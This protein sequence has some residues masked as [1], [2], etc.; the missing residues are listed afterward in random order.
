MNIPEKI[1]AA[2]AGLSYHGI[3]VPVRHLKHIRDAPAFVVFALLS[4]RGDFYSDDE[5]EATESVYTVDLFVNGEFAALL[6]EVKHRLK[7][8]GFTIMGT[9]PEIWE[10]GA[11]ESTGERGFF[12]IP[13]EVCIEQEA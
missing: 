4:Q 5:E 13:I 1:M 11:G 6:K 9:G 7:R 3:P 12:H 8:T 10:R 2:L